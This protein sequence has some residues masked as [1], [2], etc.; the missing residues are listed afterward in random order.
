MVRP[1]VVA[2][3]VTC[4]PPNGARAGE[5]GPTGEASRIADRAPL[6]ARIIERPLQAPRGWTALTLAVR[7]WKRVEAWSD[8]GAAVPVGSPGPLTVGSLEVRHGVAQHVEMFGYAELGRSRSRDASARWIHGDV[9]VGARWA[10]LQ[11]DAPLRALAVHGAVTGPPIDG[12]PA[13]PLDAPHVSAGSWSTELGIAGRHQVG[14]V[15]LTGTLFATTRSSSRLAATRLLADPLPEARVRPGGTLAA[16]VDAVFQAGPATLLVGGRG[17]I[18][19]A[20][21]D[22]GGREPE[23]LLAPAAFLMTKAGAGV[24]VTRACD[25]S[26]VAAWPMTGPASPSPVLPQDQIAAPTIEGRVQGWF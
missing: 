5:H 11:R 6:P 22:V 14:P 25:L 4:P 24:S 13:L 20:T 1:V 3:L 17:G 16:T 8:A 19:G 12:V 15:A 21:V 7:R 2:I 23:P 10:L 18:V 9:S 26:V